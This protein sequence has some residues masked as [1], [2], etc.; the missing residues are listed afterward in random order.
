M[1]KGWRI[2]DEKEWIA[3]LKH[4]N[5]KIHVAGALRV[6]QIILSDQAGKGAILESMQWPSTLHRISEDTGAR[7][8][9]E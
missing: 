5:S 3:I 4:I 1:E 7:Q 2:R 6:C 9:K 8:N